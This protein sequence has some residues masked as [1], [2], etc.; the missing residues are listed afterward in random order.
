MAE[1]P[2]PLTAQTLQDL[3]RQTQKLFDDMYTDRI[4]GA[5]IGDVFE[6]DSADILSLK[7]SSS[8]GIEKASAELKIKVSS[9]G[10]LQVAV[11]GISI[12]CKADGGLSTSADGVYLTG[13]QQDHIIDAEVAHA[14]TNP[15]DSPVSADALRDDLV[16]NTLPSIN[17]ALNNI[18]TKLNSILVALETATLLKTS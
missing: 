15:G 6:I 1:Q 14:V 7:L 12:K 10:G 9:T 11:A 18:G 16:A 8:G 13:E 4:G 3:I 2:F 17:T 5:L